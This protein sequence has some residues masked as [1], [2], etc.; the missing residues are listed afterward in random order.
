M[1]L[2]SCCSW[3][4]PFDADR[5]SSS[6]PCKN[7]PERTLSSSWHRV[8]LFDQQ[9][10]LHTLFL[11]S[12]FH[13]PPLLITLSS[14]PFPAFLSSSFF[15]PS[16]S[17]HLQ[18]LFSWFSYHPTIYCSHLIPAHPSLLLFSFLQ[19]GKHAFFNHGSS[20]HAFSN[21]AGAWKTSTKFGVV[22]YFLS[23]LN[24]NAPGNW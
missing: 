9:G 1:I 15:P 3:F 19:S 4:H 5:C 11:P 23:Y 21:M 8:K 24:S 20:C 17:S 22:L 18:R 10:S 12:I 6:H 16:L 7:T 2:Y 14:Q 13:Y